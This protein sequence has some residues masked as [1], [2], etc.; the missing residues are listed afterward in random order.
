MYY[1]SA[2]CRLKHGVIPGETRVRG[3]GRGS[4]ARAKRGVRKQSRPFGVLLLDQSNFPSAIPAFELLLS[5]DRLPDVAEHFKPN[6]PRRRI[7]L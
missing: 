3:E 2:D 6:E 5:T 4:M 1:V 7:A